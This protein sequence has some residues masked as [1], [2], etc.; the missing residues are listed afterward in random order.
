MTP[1]ASPGADLEARRGAQLI[2]L[3]DHGVYIAKQVTATL[4]NI[5]I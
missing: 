1:K 3:H 2:F 4:Y 5:V